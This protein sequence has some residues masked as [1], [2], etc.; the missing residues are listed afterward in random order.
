[1]E[2]FIKLFLTIVIS[3][4][5]FQFIL[6]IFTLTVTHEI[7]LFGVSILCGIPFIISSSVKS[8]KVI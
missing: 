8:R 7:K 2:N 5:L 6:E 1:M 4:F 3:Y